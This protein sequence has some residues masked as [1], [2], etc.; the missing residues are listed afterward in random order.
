VH[1]NWLARHRVRYTFTA[2][3]GVT[4]PV[5]ARFVTFD[6]PLLLIHGWGIGAALAIECWTIECRSIGLCDRSIWALRIG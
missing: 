6:A 5:V 1:R 3:S 4:L 2:A